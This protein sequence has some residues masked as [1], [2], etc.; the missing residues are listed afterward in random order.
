MIRAEAQHNYMA[1]SQ[2]LIVA[3]KIETLKRANE[4]S[5][6]RGFQ[7]VFAW[8]AFELARASRNAGDLN[9]AESMASKAIAIMRDV[10]DRSHLPQHLNLLA[11]IEAS[12]GNF[13][14]ADQLYTEATDVIDALLVN[15]T[16]RQLKSSLI[17]TL[18]EAYVSHFE[19]AATKF[20]DVK[21][22]Y[23]IIETAR[24][25]T[26]A[27]TLRGGEAESLSSSSDQ[28]SLEAQ[29]EINRIQ[30]ALMHET[31]RTERQSLLDELFAQEQLLMPVSKTRSP[32]KS[33]ADRSR[34]IPVRTLQASLGRD[35]MLLEYV[36]AESQSYCLQI[37]RGSAAVLVI[38]SGRKRIEALV[39]DYLRDIRSRNADI[40]AGEEL[41]TLLV[42]P[43][44]GKSSM[45]K[46]VVI[47]DGGLHLLPFDGLKTPDGKY[48]LETHVVTYAP[49]ATVL[50]LLRQRHHAERPTMSFLGIGDVIYPRPTAATSNANIDPEDDSP[51]FFNVNGVSFPDLPGSRQELVAV[52]D[53]VK[54]RKQL[55]LGPNATEA[56]VKAVAL[57]DYS[58]IHFAVHGL[59]NAQF[60]DRA[61]LVLGSS[62]GRGEDG[63]LQ[64]REIRDLPLRADLVVLS[65]CDTGNG[66][67]LGEEGIASLE[68]AFLLAGAKAV[69][70]SLW[71]T[72]DTYTIALMRQLY[73]HLMDGADKGSALRQAKLDLLQQFG[74][75]A[76]PVYWA[77]FTLVGDGSGAIF[78]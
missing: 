62:P 72:D 37:R 65:A 57:S 7:H 20:A 21:K 3:G 28:V 63:L 47:P 9:S 74:D 75:Q 42:K 77:A 24:G 30:L 31:N 60:P 26:L 29:H 12:K 59:G 55:L 64:A 35:E 11:Q 17:A 46:L 48:I 8:S 23:E 33:A 15:V 44:M 51:D 5:Q 34:P 71:T 69:I 18:S 39:A 61:A 32:L 78:N 66:R 38:P 36:L 70:A 1:M 67:L 49:S 43:A 4:I 27:D 58:I 45:T 50:H 22:A 13:E 54:G 10:E 14:L 56:A 41:F 40:A 25:R 52:A 16:R 73:Q 68:R 6:T 19:L 2:L 53:I 76:L